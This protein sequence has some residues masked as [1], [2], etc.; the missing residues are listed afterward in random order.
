L[1]FAICNLQFSV[2]GGVPLHGTA[3]VSGSKNAALPMMAAAI[4]ADGPVRLA[5][6]PELTDMRTMAMLL[7]ELGV[8]VCRTAEDLCMESVDPRPVRARYGLVRR[9][10]AGFCVLGPLVARRC[11]AVVPLPGGCQIGDRP[12]D[13][14]LR[15]LAA[16]GADV[17]LDRGYVVASARRLRGAKIDLSG[18][19]GP[20]V[21]GT[22]NVLM[23]AVL[24]RGTT[25]LHG[26]AQEPE[27]VDL[28]ELLNAMGARIEGLGTAT[29]E[30][31]GVERLNGAS[32]RV[33]PD[34]IEAAT[35]LLAAAITGGSATVTNV[36]PEHLSL[37]LEKLQAAV[38]RITVGQIANLPA[39]EMAPGRSRQVGNPPHITLTA[40]GPPQPVDVV[41]APYPGFPTDLQAQWT[42]LMSLAQGTSVVEDRIF[43][44]RFRHVAELNRLGARIECRE[45]RAI[46]TGPAR[47]TG[48]RVT[49]SDLRAS[50]ALVLAG[51]AASETTVVDRI[52]HLDRGYERLEAKLAQL[53]ARI[54]RTPS[55][56]R[57]SWAER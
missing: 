14:H 55:R 54:L 35:L 37:V 6:A 20:S 27:I 26:A 4:L 1:Q 49:A 11:K 39:Q 50:A 41:A 2:A 32:H 21:T 5:N 42:A 8:S 23:A 9:M 7:R 46:V 40:D 10:R 34:R 44:A 45:G 36:C 56:T 52:R 30:V 16:L 17:R 38:A 51:L 18:P 15:G 53:G 28:G 22:A 47:L 31:R 29:L 33:I 3:A 57:T 48:T 12:V 24:A 25:V 19:R 13:L 43:P